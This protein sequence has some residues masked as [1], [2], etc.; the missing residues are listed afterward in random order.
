MKM[1]PARGPLSAWLAATLH[2]DP[3]VL[4][5]GSKPLPVSGPAPAGPVREDDDLQLAL[6]CCYELHYRGFDDV[7]ERWEWHPAIIGFRERLEQPWLASLQRFAGH[8]VAAAR[9]PAALTELAAQPGGPGL[10]R[11]LA[12]R[13]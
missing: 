5:P 4:P 12:R 13:A 7:D 9:V 11:Y 10:D 1:P 8:A 2:G 3:A 6:W